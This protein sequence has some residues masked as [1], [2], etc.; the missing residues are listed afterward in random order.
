MDNFSHGGNIYYY[1]NLIGCNPNE[2]IDLSSNISPFVDENIFEFIKNQLSNLENLPSSNAF[3]LKEAL[4]KKYD[5]DMENFVVGVGTSEIIKNLCLI[6]SGNKAMIIAPTYID[7]E[8]YCKLYN[9]HTSFHFTSERRNFAIN[10]QELDFSKFDITFI[11]N[12]NNPTGYYIQKE[13]IL[14]AA[15]LFENCLFVIDES[16]LPFMI[17]SDNASLLFEKTKNII[18]LRSFSKIYGLAGLRIGHAFSF[19]KD[20]IREIEKHCLE[21]GV[22]SLSEVVGKYLLSLETD[23]IAS[24]INEI[25]GYLYEELKC[26]NNIKPIP[27]STNFLLIK[28]THLNSEKV[29]NNLLSNKILIR[30]CKNIRGLDDLFIR[31]AIKDL[32]SMKYFLSVFKKLVGCKN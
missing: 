17:D 19:N 16:Y 25:K 3:I 9:L 30:D 28:L 20:N 27:S 12:P 13:E 18:V 26:C 10:L 7:Y 6:N 8:K 1:A 11:C 31:V 4:A 14:K 2:I 29:F 22:S 15:K 23:Q 24:K 21:W 32:D 5:K